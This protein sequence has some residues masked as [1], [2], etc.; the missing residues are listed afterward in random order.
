MGIITGGINSSIPRYCKISAAEALVKII[1]K[2]TR[3]GT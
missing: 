2:A 3:K 1:N